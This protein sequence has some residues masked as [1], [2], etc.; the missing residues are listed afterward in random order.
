MRMPD[1]GNSRHQGPDAENKHESH[2]KRRER[3]RSLHQHLRVHLAV[4]PGGPKAMNPSAAGE[5]SELQ[6]CE[7]DEIM[8]PHAA[9]KKSSHGNIKKRQAADQTNIE[10]D[11]EQRV[12]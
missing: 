1:L 12:S 6:K 2:A 10:A 4:S 9:A 5:A 11:Y 8:E 3:A 7:G